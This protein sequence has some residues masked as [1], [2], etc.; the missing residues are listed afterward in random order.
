[1]AERASSQSFFVDLAKL[2]VYAAITTMPKAD[3]AMLITSIHDWALDLP[4]TSLGAAAC[5]LD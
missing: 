4:S 5:G 1:M 2:N 3:T